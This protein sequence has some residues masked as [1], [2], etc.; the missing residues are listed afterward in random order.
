MTQESSSFMR[1]LDMWTQGKVIDA[2]ENALE[3]Y[4]HLLDHVSER[5]CNERLDAVVAQIKKDIRQKVLES[6]RNGQKAPAAH[7]AKSSRG[8][9]KKQERNKNQAGF[10]VLVEL[11]SP[12]PP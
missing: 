10:W 2:L 6:Y 8:S 7:P 11:G 12:F 1:D 4:D 3:E 9:T 5:E